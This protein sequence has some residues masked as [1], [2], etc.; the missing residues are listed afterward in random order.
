MPQINKIERKKKNQAPRKETDMRKLRQTAYQNKEWRKLREVYMHKHPICADCLA[1]G[2]VTP[3]EDIHHAK[4]PF[5]NGEVNWGLLLDPDNL[6]SLCKQCHSERHNRERGIKTV[7]QTLEDLDN[8]L[9]N[10]NE[11]NMKKDD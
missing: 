5:I 3:A 7:Q 4:S 11:D 8:L 1:K 2:K 9:Y 6:V 10:N